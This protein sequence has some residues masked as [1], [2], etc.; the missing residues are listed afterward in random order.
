M[1]A[2]QINVLAFPVL[3]DLKQIDDT[4]ETRLSRQPWRDIRQADRFD[5]IDFDLTLLHTVPGADLDMGT[6]P[7]PDAASNFSAPNSVAKTLRENHD[8]S[9]HLAEDGMR[10][11]RF[12]PRAIIH[13]SDYP[14]LEAAQQAIDIHFAKRN[15]NFR[16]HPKKAGSKIWGAERVSTEFREGNNCKDPL[17][18]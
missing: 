13:N 11:L 9:L 17:Y 10:F 6:G 2:N 8:E 7:D 18:R 14:S 12:R 4:Q 5:G 3:R 1:E 15:E 16:K